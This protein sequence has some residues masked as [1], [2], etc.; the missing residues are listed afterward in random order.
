VPQDVV[1]ACYCGSVA[2]ADCQSAN[3]N[4][5]CHTQ[6]ERALETSDKAKQVERLSQ[7]IYGGAQA[8]YRIACDAFLCLDAGCFGAP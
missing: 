4:G 3:A 5:P 6:F 1:A 7:L 2:F 8:S